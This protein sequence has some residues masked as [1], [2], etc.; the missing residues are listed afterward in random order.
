[1]RF[2]SSPIH[3]TLAAIVA[4]AGCTTPVS[5]TEEALAADSA[6]VEPT[7]AASV[8]ADLSGSL[9]DADVVHVIDISADDDA[10]RSAVERYLADGEKEWISATVTIDGFT[11]ENVGL[12]LK[13]NS[14]LR[15][16]T[17]DAA[18]EELPWLIRLDE[19]VEGQ[20]HEGYTELVVR[21]NNTE[22]ALNEAVALELLAE[23]G[24]ASQS[25]VATSLSVNDSE[26]TLRLVIEHPDDTW[27]SEQ[28]ADDGALYK[29]ESTGDYSYRGTDSEAYDEVFDQEAGKDTTDLTPLIEFLDFVNNSDEETF[30]D[31]LGDHLDVE[32]FARY[33]AMMELV[34]NFDD[35]DGP[36]NNSYLFYDAETER[37]TVVPWDLNLAFGVT[38]GGPG[39]GGPAGRDGDPNAARPGGMP[40]GG[41][42]GPGS[43][44]GSNPLVERFLAVDEFAALTDAALDQL[45]SDLFDSGR[46]EEI[47]DRWTGVLETVPELIDADTVAAEAA[48]IREALS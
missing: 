8:V 11:Y 34:D 44:G 30:A 13:G 16:I 48:T 33:L 43:M 17:A 27:M 25:A 4:I 5:S 14:S 3:L 6:S 9:F 15:D 31:E 12:R 38:Q 28:F 42:A 37:F 21:S 24:L 19:Y 36:G 29:A 22:T 18:P 20:Q 26:P 10:I 39:G 40:P 41:A 45:Q 7:T 1:M 35:I 2:R 32:A 23:A 47:L 46:A